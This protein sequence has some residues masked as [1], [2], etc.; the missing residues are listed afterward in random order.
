MYNRIF[1]IGQTFI[2]TIFYTK[3]DFKKNIGTLIEKS[4]FTH[5]H[6]IGGS[7]GILVEFLNLEKKK[8]YCYDIDKYNITKSRKKYKN[9]KNI[10]FI[11]K[12]IENI[13]IKNNKKSLVLLIGVIHHIDNDLVKKF[14]KRNSN[15]LSIIAI[16]PFYHKNQNLITQ[17]L[18]YLSLIHI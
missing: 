9:K 1:R 8:Y 18:L 15:K 11:N 4:N 7:D 13:K 12:S 17:L 5:I 10:T 6:D 14:L 2:E 16:D 3:N